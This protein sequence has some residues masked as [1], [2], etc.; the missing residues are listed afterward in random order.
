[1]KGDDG[2][3]RHRNSSASA[4]AANACVDSAAD[5]HYPSPTFATTSTSPLV[6]ATAGLVNVSSY[7][8]FPATVC[9]TVVA[10]SANIAVA[11]TT[12]ASTRNRTTTEEKAQARSVQR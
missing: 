5:D 1:M 3:R 9:D 8:A 2:P 11:N 6:A 4:A 10:R 7:T 12:Y